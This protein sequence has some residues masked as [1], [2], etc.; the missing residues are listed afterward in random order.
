VPC[1]QWRQRLHGGGGGIGG[2]GSASAAEIRGA[3]ARRSSDKLVEPK[4][5]LSASAAAAATRRHAIE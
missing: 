5:W 2:G 1:Q 4:N 3:R